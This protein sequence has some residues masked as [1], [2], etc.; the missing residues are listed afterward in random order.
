[1]PPPEARVL[2]GV[3]EETVFVSSSWVQEWRCPATRMR[4]PRLPSK[5]LGLL[6]LVFAAAPASASSYDIPGYLPH[7]D[8]EI[9][10]NLDRHLA[11]VHQRVVWTNHSQRPADELVFNV[12]SH[13]KIPDA[14]IGFMAKMLE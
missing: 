4:V 2:P 6:L 9:Q 10:L 3:R 7:Y 8:L 11:S 5:V 14:D 1:M 12:H 13:Y